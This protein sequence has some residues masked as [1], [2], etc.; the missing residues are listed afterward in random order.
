M[1]DDDEPLTIE[2][3]GHQGRIAYLFI[4]RPRCPSCNSTR[5]KTTRSDFEDGVRVRHCRCEDC[6]GR[7]RLVIE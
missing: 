6:G 1:G 5:L 3:A 4:R 7:V 2:R